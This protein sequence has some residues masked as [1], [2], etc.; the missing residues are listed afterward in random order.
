MILFWSYFSTK[1][2][3]IRSL[4]SIQGK[5]NLLKA[6]LFILYLKW[7][8][9]E[10]YLH[11]KQGKFMTLLGWS[12]SD[13]SI[14]QRWSGGFCLFSPSSELYFLFI[15]FLTLEDKRNRSHEIRNTIL[16]D[17][18][19]TLKFSLKDAPLLVLITEKRANTLSGAV[20]KTQLPFHPHYVN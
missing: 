15:F 17:S 13:Q 16:L 18:R 11:S 12:G 8:P 1:N 20:I 4:V 3:N 2:C 10:K 14:S 6:T 5:I 19:Y 7:N 9:K